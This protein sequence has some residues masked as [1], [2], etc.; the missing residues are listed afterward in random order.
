MPTF[1]YEKAVG[2]RSNWALYFLMCSQFHFAFLDELSFSIARREKMCCCRLRYEGC[3]CSDSWKFANDLCRLRQLASASPAGSL[4]TD[5]HWMSP[6]TLHHFQT[7]YHVGY[8]TTPSRVWQSCWMQELAV[9]VRLV[10]WTIK[11]YYKECMIAYFLNLKKGL[12]S[13]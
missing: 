6:Q 1:T 5:L 4:T 7:S 13:N 3:I 11:V 2:C 12:R 9:L 8:Q 10:H